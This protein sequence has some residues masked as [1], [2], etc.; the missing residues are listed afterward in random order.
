MLSNRLVR[1]WMTP[2]PISIKK[3]TK[4]AEA[5][6]LMSDYKIRRLPIMEGE[7]LIGI[8][9]IGDVRE[10][11]PSDATSLNMWEINYLLRNLSVEQI[12]TRDVITV[13]ADVTVRDA[14]SLMM[15]YKISGLPVMEA[16]KLV[17]IITE[18]DIFRMIV[19]TWEMELVA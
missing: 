10:A 6:K 5:H 17:G 13:E 9:T 11:E 3:T 2:N 7:R 1:D 8:I 14:A 16:G 12:M 18:S 4:L 19:E 15:E